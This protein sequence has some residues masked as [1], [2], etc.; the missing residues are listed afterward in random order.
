MKKRKQ[1]SIP[2]KKKA[3]I[4]PFIDD[5]NLKIVMLSDE[6][7]TKI[8]GWEM[9]LKKRKLSKKFMVKRG[10]IIKAFQKMERWYERKTSKTT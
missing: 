8:A 5:K 2:T 9:T 10:A 3:T 1:R 7:K 4:R 6:K